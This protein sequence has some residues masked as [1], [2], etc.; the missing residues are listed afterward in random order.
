MDCLYLNM[1]HV[2]VLQEGFAPPEDNG[3]EGGSQNEEEY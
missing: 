3:V 2:L 1:Q